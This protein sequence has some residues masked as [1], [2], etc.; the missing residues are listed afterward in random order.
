MNFESKAKVGYAIVVALLA[1]GMAHSIRELSSI[2]S[3]QV[4]R[5]RMHEDGITLVE[6]LRWRSEALVAAGR[7]YLVSG[8]PDLLGN[9]LDAEV[10]FNENIR[11]LSR[12]PLSAEG[13][14]LV[15]MAAQTAG[16][17]MRVQRELLAARQRSEDP[18][19]LVRQF[20]TELRPLRRQ[21]DQSLARLVEYKRLESRRFYDDAKAERAR[22]EFRMYGLLGLL[23]LAGIGVAWY[24]GTRLGRAY[25]QEHKAFK[26]ARGALA[27]RDEI[28]GIV[29]HDLRNPLGA[30]TIKAAML[31]NGAVSVE[32]REKAASIELVALR[33]EHLIRTMLD[34]TT[35]EA[36][37]FSVD[38]APCS[39]DEILTE[40][41][42]MFEPIA[43]S[44]QI[45]IEH[46][47][48]EPGLSVF[49]DRERVLQVLSNLVGN[50]LKFTDPGGHVSV[51]VDRQATMARFAVQDT[52]TGIRDENLS[53][54]FDRFW[55]DQT[56]GKKG[57]GLGLFIAKGIVVAHGGHIWAES[58][59][60]HGS[61]FYFTLPLA[62]LERREELDAARSSDRPSA[63]GA[64]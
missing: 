7:G 50:A 8:D 13:R 14:P 60:G 10:H 45:Q 35:M 62:E 28:I 58:E 53:H 32:T 4:A 63:S 43:E 3:D 9:A 37:Q 59:P 23:V 54:I 42:A 46:S 19:M 21:L 26:A 44:K 31:R 25:R 27:A 40:I 51:S 39:V 34:V 20:D 5:L 48:E 1:F 15:A 2:A 6:R 12:Q 38:P 55:K 61:S 24:F 41:A 22:Y 52:G 11:A 47:L 64:R 33:M 29:A 57:T 18:R 17:F 56:P 16:E 30:I 49:A 36:G